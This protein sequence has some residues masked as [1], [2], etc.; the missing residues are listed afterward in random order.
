MTRFTTSR[1]GTQIAYSRQGSG[2][3]LILIDGAFCHRK[4]GANVRLPGYLTDHFEVITY[5]RRGRGESENTLPYS[6]E[7]EFEDL[8]AVIE[9]TGR[10]PF[11]YG[12]SSGAALALE[13]VK[14]GLAFKKLT[15]FE[16]PYITDHSRRPLP[17]DYLSTIQQFIGENRPGKAVR[18]FMETGVGLPKPVVWLMQLMPAWKK[19]KEIA[20][21]L[22]YDTLMLKEYG[23]GNLLRKADWKRVDIPVLVISGTKSEQWSQNAMKNLAEVLPFGEHLSLAGQSHLVNPKALAPHIYA[24]FSAS[25]DV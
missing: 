22:E 23:Q 1:D 2:H 12:I 15:V 11:V 21:T 8:N 4:F 5:D 24:Y 13:A 9:V 18:Y 14:H 7:R 19:M 20:H 10:E 6:M 3:P 25:S 17:P 16:A